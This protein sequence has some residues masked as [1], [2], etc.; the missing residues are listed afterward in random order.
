MRC[1]FVELFFID[2]NASI[3]NFRKIIREMKFLCIQKIEFPEPSDIMINQLTDEQ[4]T[5]LIKM[6]KEMRQ[7]LVSNKVNVIQN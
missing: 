4:A 2:E 1:S 6:N 5:L 3:K 7:M